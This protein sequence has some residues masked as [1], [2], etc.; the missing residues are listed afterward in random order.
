MIGSGTTIQENE[1]TAQIAARQYLSSVGAIY[2]MNQMVLLGIDPGISP[3]EGEIVIVSHYTKFTR[4]ENSKR[5]VF[6]LI[7]IYYGDGLFQFLI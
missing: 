3:M 1:R 4:P 6:N 5:I 2:V 7:L